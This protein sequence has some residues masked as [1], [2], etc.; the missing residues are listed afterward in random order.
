MLVNSFDTK[1]AMTAS[2]Y[3]VLD[4]FFTKALSSNKKF[5][6]ILHLLLKINH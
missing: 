6:R 2:K 3:E 4:N 5:S 1:Y